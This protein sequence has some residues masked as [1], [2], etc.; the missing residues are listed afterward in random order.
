[1]LER[2]AAITHHPIVSVL[3]G[4]GLLMSGFAEL[5]DESFQ[6]FETTVKSHHGLILLGLVTALRGFAEFIEGIVWLSRDAEAAEERGAAEGHR[7]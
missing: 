5:L 6:E 1:V 2:L 3:V 7:R 4:V